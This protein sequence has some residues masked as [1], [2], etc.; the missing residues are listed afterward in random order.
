MSGTFVSQLPWSYP[1]HRPHWGSHVYGYCG[2]PPH[3][4][5]HTGVTESVPFAADCHP[6]DRPD[7]LRLVRAAPP[8][9][10]F[11]F[12]SPHDSVYQESD[13]SELFGRVL[14]I[15]RSGDRAAARK[16]LKEPE[17]RAPMEAKVCRGFIE[18]LWSRGK[19]LNEFQAVIAMGERCVG[20]GFSGALPW[21]ER[22]NRPF[23][24]A[25]RCVAWCQWRD[26]QPGAARRMLE[27]LLWL[28]PSDALGA[29]VWVGLIDGGVGAEDD[30][31]PELSSEWWFVPGHLRAGWD[32]DHSF[33][34]E[35][36]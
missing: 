36:S 35:W 26:G 31:F 33:P 8:R 22:P 3:G 24:V 27:S 14:A 12:G 6:A 4:L 34:E 17:R 7:I 10:C 28:D 30:G 19:A 1:G 25:L 21:S 9:M 11:R 2:H 20:P 15:A 16:Q 5:I 18:L 13:D 32:E 23:L 29:V